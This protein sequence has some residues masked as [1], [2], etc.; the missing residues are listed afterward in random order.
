MPGADGSRSMPISPPHVPGCRVPDA[1]AGWRRCGHARPLDATC[2]TY[3]WLAGS[4]T[5]SG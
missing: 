3:P 4:G 1:P 2:R 5:G